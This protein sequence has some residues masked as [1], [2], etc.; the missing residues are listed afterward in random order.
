[1][2][3]N[4]HCLDNVKTFPARKITAMPSPYIFRVNSRPT[5]TDERTWE[6][7]YTE[8]HI[9]ELIQ[10]KASTRAALYREVYDIPW[11]YEYNLE[12][13]PRN[14]LTVYQTDHK[15]LLKSEGVKETRMTS[16]LFPEKDIFKYGEFDERNYEMIHDFDPNGLGD[17]MF[18][19]C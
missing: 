5:N 2:E 6:K 15:E 11:L 1:M 7:W 18:Y 10:N 9:P 13:N 17:S 4:C 3:V 14:Y 8:E 19:H 12:K 16:E